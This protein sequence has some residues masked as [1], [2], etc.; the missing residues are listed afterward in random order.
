MVVAR[1]LPRRRLRRRR[2]QRRVVAA[3]KLPRRR[4]RR[5]EGERNA[6][7][8]QRKPASRRSEIKTSSQRTDNI[9][10]SHRAKFKV[11]RSFNRTP[12]F[13]F[14]AMD[15]PKGMGLG[16]GLLRIQV[17]NI[18]RWIRSRV[19]A[20]LLV[21]DLLD[22]RRYSGGKVVVVKNTCDLR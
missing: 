3:R 15:S 13:F 22:L 21:S 14:L 16:Q 11:G 5:R 19:T 20:S 4:L 18:S 17:A 1:R 7:L 2:P 8:F 9:S 12:H 6:D 10:K